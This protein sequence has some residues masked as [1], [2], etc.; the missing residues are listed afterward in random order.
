MELLPPNRL[1]VEAEDMALVELVARKLKV[2]FGAASESEA[3]C[4][5]V[6]VG[7]GGSGVKVPLFTAG[8][9]KVNVG[10]GCGV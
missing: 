4:P 2:C 7:F 3:L 10:G 5:K 6:K 9:P 8:L 1:R